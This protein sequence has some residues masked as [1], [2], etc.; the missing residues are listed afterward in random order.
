MNMQIKRQDTCCFKMF[1][2]LRIQSVHIAC[3]YKR[4]I[5]HTFYFDEDY[6][7]LTLEL[8]NTNS[9]QYMGVVKNSIEKDSTLQKLCNMLPFLLKS[10]NKI[11]S[12]GFY[13]SRTFAFTVLY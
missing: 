6:L 5:V 13:I 1:G 9:T 4:Q 7:T 3:K 2:G 12:Y 10:S 8:K 11:N